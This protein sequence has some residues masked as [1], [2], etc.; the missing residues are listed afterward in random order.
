MFRRPFLFIHLREKSHHDI[1]GYNLYMHEAIIPIHEG[2]I[3]EG[4]KTPW[5]IAVM[6]GIDPV[7][8]DQY[9]QTFYRFTKGFNL[10]RYV[11]MSLRSVV[12]YDAVGLW[13]KLQPAYAPLE[14]H[15]GHLGFDQEVVD[16]YGFRETGQMILA[17]QKRGTREIL[18][19]DVAGYMFGFDYSEIGVGI[20][21]EAF[22]SRVFTQRY[23]S[24]HLGIN[25]KFSL[26]KA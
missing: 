24:K 17:M 2:P 3:V 4:R 9:L 22:L 26:T 6:E 11:M 15:M 14:F 25:V 16:N 12:C 18:A 13:Q 23:Q 20:G 5:Q 21:D 8:R 19:V 1:I 7:I 10:F